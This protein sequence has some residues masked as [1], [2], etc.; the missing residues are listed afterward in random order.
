[1][2]RRTKIVIVGFLISII[3]ILVLFTGMFYAALKLS[4]YNEQERLGKLADQLLIR[5]TLTYKETLKGLR[6]AELYSGMP[7][8]REH[9]SKLRQLTIESQV[10]KSLGYYEKGR[11]KCATWGLVTQSAVRSPI[12]YVTEDG[13][14]VSF[15]VTPL[16]S[17]RSKVMELSMGQHSSLVDPAQITNVIADPDIGLGIFHD[18]YGAI[19]QVNFPV[20]DLFRSGPADVNRALGDQYI[21]AV[22]RSRGWIAIATKP[23]S[24]VFAAHQQEPLFLV[25]F[26]LLLAGAIV[27]GVIYWSRKMLSLQGELDLAIRKREFLVHYQPIIALETGICVGAE[28]LLRW[29]KPGGKMVPPDIF[30]TLAERT[31]QIR[32]ITD[33]LVRSVTQE[34]SQLLHKYPDLHIAINLCSDDL[35]SGRILEVIRKYRKDAG[36]SARQIWLEAT[37]RGF[38]NVEAACSTLSTIRAEGHKV[39]IDDFGTGYSSLQ[40]LQDLPIDTLK[41]DKSFVDTI[42]RDTATSSVTS[43]VIDMAKSLHLTTIAEGVETPEQADYL[44]SRGVEYGQGW[45]FSKPLPYADFVAFVERNLK[46]PGS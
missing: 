5:N 39:A 12:D 20:P 35:H 22:A 8:S 31:G 10:I 41:I 11:L 34:T 21:Y 46:R 15:A 1:M 16:I 9:I 2:N 14:N 38:M 24:T 19:A 27:G 26:V 33:L 37:E 17:P 28:A 13:V 7:C 32:E 30:I 23:R 36:L 45:L 4:I 42:G 29:R 3:G 44:L 25:P 43:H 6:E 40:Y 18:H